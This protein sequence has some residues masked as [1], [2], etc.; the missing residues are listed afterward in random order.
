MEREDITAALASRLVAAQFPQWAELPVTPVRVDG[1][2][3]TTF[4][5]GA[6]MSV[7][8]PTAQD[9]VPQ[10]D[11]EH[12]WL[13]TL[14]TQLPLSIPEPLAK[15]APGSG[16]PW[17]WSVYRWL[18]G[19]PATVEGISDLG[20]FAADLGGFLAALQRVDPAG[21][22]PPSNRKLFRGGPLNNRDGETRAAIAALDDRIDT[23]A[24]TEVWEA[25][26]R[27]PRN[28]SPVWVH[29]DVSPNNLLVVDGRLSAVIDFGCSGVGDPACDLEV[30]WGLLFGESRA[31]FRAS[32]QL[33]EATWARGRG[34][35]LWAAV[36]ALVEDLRANADWASWPRLVIEQVLAD[37]E[38]VA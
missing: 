5:L 22:P 23:S 35:K 26:L 3:N 6:D 27:A 24:A 10:V 17:P 13:P 15:G 8:L 9:Y 14:S 11:K 37:H 36:V 33:D 12:R 32:L 30:A 7:R 34:W 1:W 28:E 16:Y 29:G 20:R 25:A 21:G 2:D 19:D 4:R 31:A 38:G 18:P